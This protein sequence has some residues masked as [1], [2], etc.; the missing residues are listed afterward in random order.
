MSAGKVERTR[1]L[2]RAPAQCAESFLTDRAK[3]GVGLLTL[4]GFCSKKI[5]PAWRDLQCR[6]AWR[7]QQGH[8][9]WHLFCATS[10][11]RLGGLYSE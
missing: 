1:R 10:I 11:P 9:P 5:E 7:R 3:E 6:L 2:R 4:S 8:Q